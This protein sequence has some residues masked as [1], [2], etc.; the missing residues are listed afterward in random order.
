MDPPTDET[1]H[2]PQEANRV[3]RHQLNRFKSAQVAKSLHELISEANKGNVSKA[4]VNATELIEPE[5]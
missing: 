3:K 1:S 2:P 4:Y 5:I